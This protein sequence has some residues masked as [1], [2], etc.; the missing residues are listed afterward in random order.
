MCVAAR[1]YRPDFPISNLPYIL[2]AGLV[3]YLPRKVPDAGDQVSRILYHHSI[4]PSLQKWLTEAYPKDI[5]GGKY[6]LLIDGVSH[7]RLEAGN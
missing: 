4:L 2:Y 3:H 5:M 1:I 6:T 7:S